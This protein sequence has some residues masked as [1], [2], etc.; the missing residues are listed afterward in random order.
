MDRQQKQNSYWT[1]LDADKKY[2]LCNYLHLELQFVLVYSPYIKKHNFVKHILS[3]AI[4]ITASH[5]S[6][7]Y[8]GIKI[9]YTN[10]NIM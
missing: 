1:V 6:S 5:N 9:G 4:M 2:I 10:G 3:I 7:A 8:N